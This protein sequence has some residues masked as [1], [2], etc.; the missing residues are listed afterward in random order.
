MNANVSVLWGR[1]SEVSHALFA[2]TLWCNVDLH[3]QTRLNLQAWD[4]SAQ[5]ITM[6]THNT[7]IEMSY[8]TF[9]LN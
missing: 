5:S 4:E 1:R 8:E 9:I 3:S 6:W 2:A 7:R